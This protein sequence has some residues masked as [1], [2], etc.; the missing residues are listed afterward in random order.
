MLIIDKRLRDNFINA[1]AA[2]PKAASYANEIPQRSIENLEDL[3]LACENIY[4][5]GIIF[6]QGGAAAKRKGTPGVNDILSVLATKIFM[7]F[8]N[9]KN[10]AISQAQFDAFHSECCES[11]LAALNTARASAELVELHYGSAQKMVNMVFKYLACYQDY[12]AFAQHFK[13]CHMP[14]DTVILKWLKD[15][16]FIS[17]IYYR[18]H[19]NPKGKKSLTAKYKETAWTKFDKVLYDEVVSIARAN[20]SADQAFADHHHRS[21][22]L[23]RNCPHPVPEQDQVGRNAAFC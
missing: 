13:W 14:I 9:P 16:Y 23:L 19:I 15:R 20:I 1:L 8:A 5:S 2:K 3:L 6:Q 10:A 22:Y 21:G 18:E 11:F 12:D 4:N 7:Y 17:D